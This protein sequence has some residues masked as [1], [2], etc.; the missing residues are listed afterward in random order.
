ME[1]FGSAETNRL[2]SERFR[3]KNLDISIGGV[4]RQITDMTRHNT[5]SDTVIP[6]MH[7]AP[8]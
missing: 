5:I 2:N 7:N 3:K 8:Y 1:A 4:P 6:V